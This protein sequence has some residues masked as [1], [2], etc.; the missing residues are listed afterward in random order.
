MKIQIANLS[1][2]LRYAGVQ[3][4]DLLKL[5]LN[6]LLLAH[7]VLVASLSHLAKRL[8]E[9]IFVRAGD[10]V[11]LLLKLGDLVLEL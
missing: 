5:L 7:F 6:L 8:L 3:I 11:D 9:A 1:G 2:K 4:V 10:R